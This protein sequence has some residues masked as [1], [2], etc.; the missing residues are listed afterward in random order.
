MLTIEEIKQA[1][2]F[3][4]GFSLNREDIR[5][6]DCFY[7]SLKE[8]KAKGGLSTGFYDLFLDRVIAGYNSKLKNIVINQSPIALHLFAGSS[9][10]RTFFHDQT[11]EGIR[12]ARE[13]AVRFVLEEMK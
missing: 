13:K 11:T 7:Y 12:E 9:E 10:V 1:V 3:A 2:E 5:F 8:F 4:D 6:G